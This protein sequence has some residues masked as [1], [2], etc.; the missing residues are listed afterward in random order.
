MNNQLKWKTNIH[1]IE[2]KLLLNAIL[3]DFDSFKAE[4][5][6]RRKW[7]WKWNRWCFPDVAHWMYEFP[8][9]TSP[10]PSENTYKMMYRCLPKDLSPPIHG[11]VH[12][13]G[14][15]PS[16]RVFYPIR[17][18]GLVHPTPHPT[19]IRPWSYLWELEGITWEGGGVYGCMHAFGGGHGRV[20]LNLVLH[21]IF[22]FLVRNLLNL[23]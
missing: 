2:M 1:N 18:W 21:V 13:S 23:C 6:K 9:H 12:P 22:L 10:H 5:E 4:I 19:S 3:N 16:E 14:F 20:V 8:Y 11:L 15:S 7:V 17:V